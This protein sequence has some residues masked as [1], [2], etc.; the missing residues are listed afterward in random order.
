MKDFIF[1]IGGIALICVGVWLFF[2]L[3]FHPVLFELELRNRGVKGISY[4]MTAI[5]L[6]GII[7]MYVC[8]NYRNQDGVDASIGFTFIAFVVAAIFAAKRAKKLLL[9]G[10]DIWQLIL[11]QV[12]SPVTIVFV[13]LLASLVLDKIGKILS[14]DSDSDK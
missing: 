14:G 11:A 6:A 1:A 4:V 2:K 5:Q 12:F 3:I 7:A 9:T 8:Y 13:I 10:K